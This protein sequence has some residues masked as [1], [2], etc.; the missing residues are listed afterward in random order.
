M[1]IFFE[2]IGKKLASSFHARRDLF[3]SAI[4]ASSRKLTADQLFIV[5][6]KG[7]QTRGDEKGFRK[8]FEYDRINAKRI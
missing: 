5:F 2:E 7:N 1:K 8:R 4:I 3:S 6:R